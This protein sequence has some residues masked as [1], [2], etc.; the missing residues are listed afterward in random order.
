MTSQPA[1]F[2]LGERRVI[3][4]AGIPLSVSVA[5]DGP[6]VILMHGWP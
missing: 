2:Q 6:L 5:G 1:S 3:A 4:G